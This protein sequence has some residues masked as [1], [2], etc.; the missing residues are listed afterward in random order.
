MRVRDLSALNPLEVISLR[1]SAM[2]LMEVGV[3][4]KPSK[5]RVLEGAAEVLL[6]T[7]EGILLVIVRYGV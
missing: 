7:A 2:L 3:R 4:G 6:R 1:Y 5:E